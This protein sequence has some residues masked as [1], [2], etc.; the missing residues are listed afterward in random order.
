VADGGGS[1]PLSRVGA[2]VAT[3]VAVDVL[4]EN[5][6]Q[7]EF[8]P[9]AIQGVM[10][11]A[12]DKAYGAIEQEAAA[13]AADRPGTTMRDLAT[14]LLVVAHCPVQRLVAVGQ[15]GDGLVALQKHDGTWEKLSHGEDSGRTA[16]EVVFLT[17][18]A[19]RDWWRR[20]RQ[21]KLTAPPRFL[22]VM[23]DGVGDDVLE[24]EQNFAMLFRML[25]DASRRSEPSG[26]LLE[27]LGYDKPRS[28]DDRTLVAVYPDPP[29]SERAP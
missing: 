5:L 2:N 11:D 14:T 20:V 23:T 6:P 19:N 26:A 7:Q 22:A 12:L 17:S 1:Y 13:I 3:R 9:S 27:W 28:F 29:D 15:V 16:G 10:V 25:E 21:F 24:A 4:T 18:V 8:I